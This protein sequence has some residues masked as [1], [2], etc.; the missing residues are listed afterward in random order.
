M[1]DKFSALVAF[2]IFSFA[3]SSFGSGPAAFS[4]V[5]FEQDPYGTHLVAAEWKTGTGCPRGATTFDGTMFASYTDLGCPTGDPRDRLNRGLLLAKTGTTSNQAYAGARIQGVQ[6]QVITELGYDLRKPRSSVDTAGSHCG[7]LAPYFHVVL[8]D[9]STYDVGC[10]EEVPEGLQS[11]AVTEPF[12]LRLR[13]RPPPPVPVSQIFILFNEGQDTGPDNFGLAVLDNI[14]ING[15]LVGRGPRNFS[16]EDEGGGKDADQDEFDF[17]DSPTH[18]DSSAMEYHDR[19]TRMNLQ[20]INGVRSIAYTGACVSFG[21][22][23][24]VNGNAGYT[25]T[26][27]SCD[28]SVAGIGIGNFTITIAGPGAFLYQKSAPMTSVYVQIAALTGGGL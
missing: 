23:A 20:S 22:D 17:H 27:S 8:S 11:A 21:G 14:D 24:L 28:L 26:F 16:D 3:N 18:P 2:C 7:P 6:G 25:Y 13:F 5:P 1:K 15:V 19:S 4:V 10:F 12:W 9:G